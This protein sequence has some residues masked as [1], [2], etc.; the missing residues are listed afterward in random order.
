MR[1]LQEA[2]DEG[3]AEAAAASRQAYQ[4]LL[5][6]PKV[7]RREEG[8]GGRVAYVGLSSRNSLSRPALPPSLPPRPDRPQPFPGAA[9]AAQPRPLPHL[10]PPSLGQQEPGLGRH[11][12][13]RRHSWYVLPPPSLQA[14][15]YPLTSPRPRSLP[16]SLPPPPGTAF[17]QAAALTTR[18]H[19]ADWAQMAQTQG[20]TFK[21]GGEGGREGGRV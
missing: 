4:T 17:G 10:A 3:G 19:Q 15:I 11:A 13:Q 14:T 2:M 7:R 18:A 9:A 6:T 8:R 21:V 5:Q 12:Y 16:P 20:T 1:L